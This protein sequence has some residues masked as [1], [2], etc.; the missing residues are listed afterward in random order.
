VTGPRKGRPPPEGVHVAY[1]H[2]R[3]NP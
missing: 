2:R 3:Q 1:E